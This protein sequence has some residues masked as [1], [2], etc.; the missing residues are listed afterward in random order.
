MKTKLLF[1]AFSLF[2]LESVQAQFTMFTESWRV[3]ETEVN[4]T[5]VIS[6]DMKTSG[7]NIY[8]LGKLNN[9]SN[10][11]VVI[12]K[13]SNAGTVL[14]RTAYNSGSEDIP[15]SIGVDNSGNSYAIMTSNVAGTN[16]I[17]VVKYNTS[18][19]QQWVW[20]QAGGV[21]GTVA[22]NGTTD[23]TGV[24]YVV[25]N[26]GAGSTMRTHKISTLGT[27]TWN[28]GY[29][30]NA[31]AR[32]PSMVAVDA[33]SNVY[34][35]GWQNTTANGVDWVTLKYNSAG[36]QQWVQTYGGSDADTAK[37]LIIDG[38]S[39]V[40][41]GG[42]YNVNEA[43]VRKYTSA[44]AVS[45]TNTVDL[46]ID[47]SS[48]VVLQFDNSNNI[49]AAACR[50]I[51]SS[52]KKQ[53]HLKKIT[54]A[55][56]N[57]WD[58]YYSGTT[59]PLGQP[60][61][62]FENYPKQILVH[63]DSNYVYVGI[64]GTSKN[65]SGFVS[66]GF[67]LARF[68]TT[69][70][71]FNSTFDNVSHNFSYPD[72]AFTNTIAFADNNQSIII[73]GSHKYGAPY[74]IR[75]VKY[76]NY[77][78]IVK[79]H[80][81]SFLWS[82]NSSSIYMCDLSAMGISD[83]CRL[84]PSGLQVGYTYFWVAAV[85]ADEDYLTEYFTDRTNPNSFFNPPA[86]FFSMQYRMKIT[87]SNGA[88]F[89][90]LPV[91][92]TRH[93][94]DSSITLS[95]S[96]DLCAG[97]SVDVSMPQ[98]GLT[99]GFATM[100]KVGP[101]DQ[102]L[103]TY[104]GALV[105]GN[106]PLAYTANTSGEHYFEVEVTLNAPNDQ[107]SGYN[108]T[109]FGGCLY[110]SDTVLITIGD[111]IITG[112]TPNS[113][114][115]TGA[116]T[117]GA[118]S[119]SG[120]INWYAAPTGGVSLGTGTS[121]VTPSI[122]STTTYYVD[123]TNGGCTT[124]SRTAVTATVNAVPTITGTTPDSRCGT[125]TV[126]LGAT[127]SAGTLNWYAAPT[128][129]VSLG[130]G[131]SFVTPSIS[132]TTTYYVDATNGGCTTASRT[133]VTATVNAVPTI[134]GTTPDS[135]CGTGT[136][137]LGATGSAGTLN[138]Y[139]APTGGVSLGTGTSF[140][141]PSIS[142][143]T[144]YYVDATNGGCTTASR[145][146]VTA[147]VNTVPTI[148]GTTPDSRC[149]TGTVTL[150]AT[151]SAGTLNWYAAPTGGVSLGTGTSFVTP[152][153]SS[154]TTYYVDATNG[155]CTSA[156]TA[157]TATVNAVPTITGTTPNSRCGNGTV[158]LGATG[159]AGTLNWYAAPTGGVSLGTG[160]SFVTPSLS[161]TTTYYVDATNGGCTTASR[162]AVTATVNFVPSQPSA[163]TGTITVCQGTTQSYSVINES[164]VT[165]DWLAPGGSI[166]GSGN[167]VS[168]TW[169]NTGVQSISVTA[170]NGCGSSTQSTLNV[171]V[172]SGSAL[173]QPGA[174][175][176]NTTICELSTNNYTISN[177][178]GALSYTWTLPGG[179]TGTSTTPTINTT[180]GTIGGVIS[181]SANNSC[182]SST[183]Q[184]LNVTVNEFP[185]IVGTT[186]DSRCGEGTVTLGATSSSGTI[187]WYAVSS[188]GA[189]LGTGTSFVTPSISSTTTYYVD[190]TN[191][192]CTT[193]SRTAVTATVNAE[194][195]A[196]VT[197]LGNTLSAQ[198][199]GLNY[200]W[201]DC[202]NSFTPISGENGQSFTAPASGNYAVE[203]TGNGCTVLSDCFNVSIAGFEDHSASASMLVYPNPAIDGK[204]TIV[205]AAP[206]SD[207]ILYD[208][209]GK[210]VYEQFS[211]GL[212]EIEIDLPHLKPGVYLLRMSNETQ[213]VLIK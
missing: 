109:S 57:A 138:W 160:T 157:V 13:V 79:G 51:Y 10:Q 128:G 200:Q 175:S 77:T 213:R 96:P 149:G 120:T 92:I 84:E 11:D 81:P 187:D 145:T 61:Q 17:R 1:I 21:L 211:N 155:G 186:P 28:I 165:Y 82:T 89:Y 204:F 68:R 121:F 106:D 199:S 24:T 36:V 64:D 97:G 102:P 32:N 125:G 203:V 178:P 3:E 183:A 140:V 111:P 14:W 71:S 166:S 117:L 25:G 126:T 205:S 104:S 83:S 210:V 95:G 152:S 177:V 19:V 131:T 63:N 48:S 59:V 88:V 78:P 4:V 139:A 6:V 27:E 143:T 148:T 147:T 118:S 135:R 144:T 23:A 151:G 132:S 194:P 189:S 184:T 47:E 38:A 37:T 107:Y 115:G 172:N 69:D 99:Y 202:D 195:L 190:A 110:S 26:D 49:Y 127:G 137:T 167:A 169:N 130:T 134:T 62:F 30:P 182:G 141:T 179:W 55:G 207:I 153:I 50:Q 31:F 45:W 22:V 101:P 150:G 129:G 44:G 93:S 9:G 20:T 33:A 170:T 53:T 54:A 41:V 67:H 174:I 91:T 119:S 146:A 98:I 133:T 113:R 60:N 197:Q 46:S 159:S 29:S 188:G 73:T 162:T 123:A 85:G 87:D 18:G 16:R 158:T 176:G 193:V 154:T 192:G 124:A 65:N 180:A 201:V 86:G 212:T 168:I 2:V 15:V 198:E 161:S 66:R 181:V 8:Q 206:L 173:P 35:C 185:A 164:G 142:S 108:F 7:G 90:S 58:Q 105:T 208:A 163:I 191:G 122:S 42:K 156:R 43:R 34:V 116:V 196:T 75:T 12:A 112:T 76:A 56:G 40:I 103:S 100:Y 5:E 171:T 136:V 52:N 70:G 94:F 39:N 114:C 72:Q 80:E 209:L 74:K